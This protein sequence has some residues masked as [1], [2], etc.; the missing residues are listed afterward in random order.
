MEYL[1]ATVEDVFRASNDRHR[2]AQRLCRFGEPRLTPGE[3]L[4]DAEVAVPWRVA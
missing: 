4:A 2:H 1:S 3:G